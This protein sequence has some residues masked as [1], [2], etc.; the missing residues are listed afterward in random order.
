MRPILVIVFISVL[1]ILPSLVFSRVIVQSTKLNTYDR[2]KKNADCKTDSCALTGIDYGNGLS[3]PV[4]TYACVPKNK[5]KSK[6]IR[7]INIFNYLFIL[8]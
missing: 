6:Q 7:L 1:C 4:K 3:K 2:C 5:C 8:K